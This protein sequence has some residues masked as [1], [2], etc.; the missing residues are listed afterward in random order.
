MRLPTIQGLIRRRIL[1]NFRVDP[2][3]MQSVIKVYSSYFSDVARFPKGSI[4]FDNALIMRN[5]AH[6]WH[7]VDDLYL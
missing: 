2:E 6:E 3:A 1:A 7:S 5:V 4:E